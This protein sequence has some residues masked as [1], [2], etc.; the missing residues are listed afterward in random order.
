MGIGVFAKD[1]LQTQ[2]FLLNSVS[3][4]FICIPFGKQHLMLNYFAQV[5]V[6]EFGSGLT[7]AILFLSF[8]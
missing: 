5:C 8:N 6:E 7:S 4:D 1:P 2:A 3:P